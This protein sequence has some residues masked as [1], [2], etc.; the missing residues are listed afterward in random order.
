MSKWWKIDK[1]PLKD[2]NFQIILNGFLFECPSCKKNYKKGEKSTYQPVSKRG[3]T[4]RERNI[5]GQ[6]LRN[7][8]NEIKKSINKMYVVSKKQD[9]NLDELIRNK[10]VENGYSD[11]NTELI[12]FVSYGKNMTDTEVIYYYIRNA[13]AHGS[14]Q[15]IKSKPKVYVFESNN[16]GLL[17]AR[18]R[19]KESTLLYLIKLAQMDPQQIKSLTKNKGV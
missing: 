7:L 13:L 8:N 19:L 1:I 14:F 17:K 3:K 6:L 4:F 10:Y 12:A 11:S 5:S 9:D 16:H 18:I 15:V 2:K